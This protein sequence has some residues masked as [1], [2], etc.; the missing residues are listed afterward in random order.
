M[1]FEQYL[2]AMPDVGDDEDFRRIEGGIREVD[3][4]R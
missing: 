4:S 2:R 3:L 1:S